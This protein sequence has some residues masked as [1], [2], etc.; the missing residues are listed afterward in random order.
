MRLEAS[1]VLPE[2]Y[3]RERRFRGEEMRFV[4]FLAI[5]AALGNMKWSV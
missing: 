1:S 5:Q 3:R 4:L 2:P